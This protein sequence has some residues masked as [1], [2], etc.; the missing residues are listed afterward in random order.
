MRNLI[1]FLSA[2]VLLPFT[3]AGSVALTVILVAFAVLLFP[4]IV[5]GAAIYASSWLTNQITSWL[6]PLESQNLKNNNNNDNKNTKYIIATASLNFLFTLVLSP[7]AAVV[8]A[9]IGA[10]VSVLMIPA[11]SIYGA[12][13]GAEKI[14]NYAVPKS[15]NSEEKSIRVNHSYNKILNGSPLNDQQDREFS[16]AN[17]PP[18]FARK[19]IQREPS[20]TFSEYVPPSP[21]SQ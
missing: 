2:L 10:F 9:I 13:E 11:L 4:L 21:N 15:G 20:S 1:K 16:D 12:V 14:A 8:S 3:S 7:P 6:F 18:P 17:F 5:L 19:T